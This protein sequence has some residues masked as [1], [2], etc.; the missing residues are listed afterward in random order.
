MKKSRKELREEILES[1]KVY[2]SGCRWFKDAPL[3]INTECLVPV[4]HDDWHSKG[5]LISVSPWEANRMRD[6]E[7]YEKK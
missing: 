1:Y 4:L 7:N 6:C 2:C 3:Y 5:H